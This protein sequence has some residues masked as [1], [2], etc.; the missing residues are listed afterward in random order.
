MAWSASPLMVT[1]PSGAVPPAG[2]V[3][4]GTAAEPSPGAPK[5]L[6]DAGR[7]SRPVCR[8]A[9]ATEVGAADRGAVG[10]RHQQH[11]PAEPE[12]TPR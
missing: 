8:R 6:S 9:S 4:V 10:L 7:R 12:R 1:E 2:D 11:E 5:P 3:P